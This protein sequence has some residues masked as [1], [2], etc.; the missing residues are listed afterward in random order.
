MKTNELKASN[1][2]RLRRW[3]RRPRRR[4]DP[5][6]VFNLSVFNSA[7]VRESIFDSLLQ[8]ENVWL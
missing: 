7:Q 8:R 1:R 4:H 2:T 3:F 6:L 5:M